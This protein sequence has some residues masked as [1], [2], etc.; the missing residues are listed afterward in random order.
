MEVANQDI[1]GSAA[2]YALIF[3]IIVF[4][5]GVILGVGDNRRVV[6]FKSYDD[7][8]FTFLVPTLLFLGFVGLKATEGNQSGGLFGIL[9]LAGLVG[10]FAA[11][12]VVIYS[13]MK[14]NSFSIWKTLVAMLVKFPL[15]FFWVMHV[16]SIVKPSGDTAAQRAKNRASSLLILA[17]LTPIIGALVAEKTGIFSPRQVLKG[18]RIGSIR[19]HL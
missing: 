15:S 2:P 8:F 17:I 4:V 12:I 9:G 19:N 18:K 5:V 13:T 7:L 1:S 3:L 10:S 6:V 11:L 14:A 16:V